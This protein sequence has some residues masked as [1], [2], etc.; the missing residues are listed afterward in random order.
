MWS[1][2][3][4]ANLVSSAMMIEQEEL[5]DTQNHGI[6]HKYM[7]INEFIAYIVHKSFENGI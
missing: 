2:G 6:H 3:Q 4:A 7:W 5:G 1:P